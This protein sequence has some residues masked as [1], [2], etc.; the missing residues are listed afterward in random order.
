MSGGQELSRLQNYVKYQLMP[1]GVTTVPRPLAR[2]V[3]DWA[4][5]QR[6][7]SEIKVHQKADAVVRSQASRLKRL[8]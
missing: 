6:A 5:D 2:V 3:Q 8:L 4:R 1:R 7:A